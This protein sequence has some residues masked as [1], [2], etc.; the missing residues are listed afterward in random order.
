VKIVV[1]VVVV[2]IVAAI[3]WQREYSREARIE[4]AYASCMKQ[5]GGT[6]APATATAPKAP[7]TPDP[8]LAESMSR[9]MQDLVKGVTAG[10]TGAVCGAVR[11]ACNADFDGVVCQNAL[12]GFK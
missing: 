9:T 3:L 1:L 7:D 2:A 12:A 6:V 5:F 11:D 4:H 8:T 10:M